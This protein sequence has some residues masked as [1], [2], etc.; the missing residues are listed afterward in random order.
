MKTNNILKPILEF[1]L[2]QLSCGAGGMTDLN[3]LF[4]S[5]KL[6]ARFL[7]HFRQL[8]ISIDSNAPP[9]KDD[10]LVPIWEWLKAAKAR[11]T[12]LVHQINEESVTLG[13]LQLVLNVYYSATEQA[14]IQDLL[15]A[16]DLS[17]QLSPQVMLLRREQLA[18][19]EGL[20]TRLQCFV[21]IYC[22]SLRV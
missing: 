21:N 11:M 22:S 16:C 5:S 1:T 3:N 9:P 10:G 20:V 12:A 15:F 18:A 8:R 13:D 7:Q 17:S 6:W 2:L 4:K 19:F 14:R